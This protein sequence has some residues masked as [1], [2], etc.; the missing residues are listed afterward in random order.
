MCCWLTSPVA[1]PPGLSEVSW[2]TTGLPPHSLGGTAIA[3]A[4]AAHS[5]P[6]TALTVTL[7]PCPASYSFDAPS[8]TPAAPLS[9]RLA[10]GCSFRTGFGSILEDQLKLLAVIPDPAT[11]LLRDGCCE[12]WVVVCRNYD[13][14]AHV[15]DIAELEAVAGAADSAAQGAGGERG[16]AIRAEEHRT[17]FEKLIPQAG[18]VQALGLQTALPTVTQTACGTHPWKMVQSTTPAFRSRLAA[19][20]FARDIGQPSSVE[21]EGISIGKCSTW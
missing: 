10:F 3:F 17:E 15:L 18:A 1:P 20:S 6:A 14:N 12:L 11:H 7:K 19:K 16:G 21:M 8:P 4:T 13:V 9:G 2:I 5:T